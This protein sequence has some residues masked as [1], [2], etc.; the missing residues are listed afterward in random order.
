MSALWQDIQYGI[1]TL[2]RTPPFSAVAALSLAL[3]IG[4]NTA[5]FTL[6]NAIL[7]QSLPFPDAGRLGSTYPV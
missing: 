3:G 6:M 5:I 7:L 1:R 2:L 4:L